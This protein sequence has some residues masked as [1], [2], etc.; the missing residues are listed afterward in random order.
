MPVPRVR[1]IGEALG[2]D[3]TRLVR[4]VQAVEELSDRAR[5]PGDVLRAEDQK[6]QEENE[7]QFQR[8]DAQEFHGD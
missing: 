4:A 5:R 2:D 8:T 1:Q 7:H 6:D 3:L